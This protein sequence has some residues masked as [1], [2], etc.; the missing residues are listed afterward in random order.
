MYWLKNR[1]KVCFGC[2]KRVP[3][4]SLKLASGFTLTNVET[5]SWTAVAGLASFPSASWYDSEAKTCNVNMVPK[6]VCGVEKGLILVAGLQ[7]QLA[8]LFYRHLQ[9]PNILID[10]Q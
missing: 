10:L 7:N 1:V 3:K 6:G 4:V 8:T 2:H 9:T 5:Q